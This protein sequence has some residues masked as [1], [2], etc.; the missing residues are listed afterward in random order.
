MS[1][2]TDLRSRRQRAD[3][4]RARASKRREDAWVEVNSCAR[5]AADMLTVGNDENARYFA[6]EYAA[7]KA[8]YDEAVADWQRARE[9]WQRALEAEREAV[10]TS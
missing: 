8:A 7:A 1:A 4:R 2:A 10:T 3:E 9:D 5:C 6:G